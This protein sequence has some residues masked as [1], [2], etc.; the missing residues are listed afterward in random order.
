MKLRNEKGRFGALS[1]SSDPEKLALRVKTVLYSIIPVVTLLAKANGVELVEGDLK[2]YADAVE[3][4]IIFG[5]LIITGLIHLW[6]W[7]RAL[8]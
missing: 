8:K 7:M 4:V 1:S 5:G 3:N 6:G 2:P